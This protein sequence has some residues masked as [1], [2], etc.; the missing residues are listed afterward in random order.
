MTG[1]SELVPCCAHEV[2]QR[3]SEDGRLLASRMHD[4]GRLCFMK[5]AKTRRW[6]KLTREGLVQGLQ[7]TSN[8]TDMYAKLRRIFSCML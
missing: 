8:S 6:C 3:S 2:W 1:F 4:V 5:F 7:S